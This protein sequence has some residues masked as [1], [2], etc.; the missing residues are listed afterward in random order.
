MINKVLQEDGPVTTTDNAGAGLTKPELPIKP[1]SVF[2]R[3]K[4][5]LKSKETPKLTSR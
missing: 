1:D 4:K 3:Y 2:R 5:L